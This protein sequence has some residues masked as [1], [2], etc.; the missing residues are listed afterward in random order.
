MS[1]AKEYPFV[2]RPVLAMIISIT[3]TLLGLIAMYLLPINR[4]PQITPPA[5]Q[6][7]AVYPGAS[8]EDVASAVAAPIEQQ[9]AGLDGLLYYNSSNSSDGTMN[10]SVYFDISR[11]QDLAAVDVQNAINLAL[12]QLPASVRQIGITV[13]KANS[14]ILLIGALMS[15]NPNVTPRFSRTTASCTSRTS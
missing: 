7:V 14:D 8:A 3:V 15:R 1:D 6:V 5:V 12:Q 11:N 9:L 4:Y 2:R 13:T 10:L